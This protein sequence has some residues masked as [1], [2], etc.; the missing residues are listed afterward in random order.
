MQPPPGL[1]APPHPYPSPEASRRFNPWAIVSISFAV[2]GVLG[3]WCFGGLIAVITGHV[4][5]HQIKRTGEGGGGLAL[6]GLIMGYVEIALF[7]LFIA[8]YVAFF[9]FIFAFA[10]AHPFPSPSPSGS[11]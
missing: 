8:A 2:S 5:R 4:A 9:V 11:Q 7:F 6:A 3:S 1:Q 10:A